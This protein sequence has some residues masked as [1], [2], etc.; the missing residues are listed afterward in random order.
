MTNDGLDPMLKAIFFDLDDTLLAAEATYHEALTAS[1]AEAGRRCAAI[2]ARR[3]NDVYL[4]VSREM[5]RS[6]E[7]PQMRESA[8]EIRT[9][10]WVEAL[11]RIG[12][13]DEAL[14]RE[15]ALHY[16]EGRR[17]GYRLFPDVRGTLDCLHRRYYL[18]IITNGVTEI[19][20]EKIARLGIEP[21]FATVLISQAVGFAKP[22]P[23]IFRLALNAVPCEPHEAVMVGDSPHRDIA[24]ARGVGMQALWVRTGR[25]RDEPV[26]SG[27]WSVVS[28]ADPPS[29]PSSLAPSGAPEQT[30]HAILERLEELLPWLERQGSG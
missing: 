10:V 22:D 8:L 26:V 7:L 12:V 18:G 13:A 19:Q 1:C 16:G 4:E 27:Q 14:A 30:A 24:G 21:Y 29:D 25:R 28:G 20:Q 6:F 9:M 23:R 3:L 11:R 17:T 15:I 5:W 2:D